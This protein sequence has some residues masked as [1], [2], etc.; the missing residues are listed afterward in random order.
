MEIGSVHTHARSCPAVITVSNAGNRADLIKF[1]FSTIDEKKIGHRVVA[2]PQVDQS[3]VVY[4]GRHHSPS[5]SQMVSDA[6]LLADV[7]E[8]PI[9]IVVEQPAGHR[10]IN[11]S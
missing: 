9:A 7:G 5:F 11:L 8:C 2:Y 6:R 10:R 4:V 1:S 3:V